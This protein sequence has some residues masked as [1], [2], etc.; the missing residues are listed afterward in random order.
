VGKDETKVAR[1]FGQAAE[2]GH[3]DA[4]RDLGV[5]CDLGTGV[6]QD[7]ATAALLYGQAAE[8]GHADVQC[9]LCIC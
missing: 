7:E 2:Q 1:L 9:D 4:K 8:Q 3:A 5:C 6:E